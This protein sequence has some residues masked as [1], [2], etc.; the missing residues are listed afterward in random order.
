M[1]NVECPGTV[2]FL[3]RHWATITVLTVTAVAFVIRLYFMGRFTEYNADSYYYMILG[4]S[5]RDSFEYTVRGLLHTKYLPG[6]P[7]AMWLVSYI[8]GGIENAA[9]LIALLCG[10]MTVVVTYGLARELF[11]RRV[12]VLAAVLIALQP[13]YLAWTSQPMTEGIFTFLFAGS[14]WLVLTGCKRGSMFRRLLGAA[15]GGACFLVRWEG[16]LLFP[17]VA[18]ILWIYRHEAGLSWWEPVAMLALGGGPIGAYA[19]RNL[20]LTGSIS[21]YVAEYS[22]Y[23]PEVISL[24]VLRTR[25][26]AYAWS[27]FSSAFFGVLAYIS[28]AWALLRK[29]W[30]PLLVMGGWFLLYL[31]MHMFWYYAYERFMA[32]AMPAVSILIAFLVCDVAG[33]LVAGD[34]GRMLPV[35]GVDAEQGGGGHLS[36][37]R[38]VRLAG[39]WLVALL[40]IG[41]LVNCF[42]NGNN[43]AQVLAD[44][45]GD[46]HGGRG[47]VRAADW[48]GENDPGSRV[49]AS[50]GPYFAWLYDSG[51][52]VYLRSVPW[53]LP[54]EE[55]TVPLTNASIDDSSI[56]FLVE[57]GVKYLVLHYSEV[58]EKANALVK[59]GEVSPGRIEQVAYWEDL[60]TEPTPAHLMTT[61]IFKVLPHGE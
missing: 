35:S 27:G 37:P 39:P 34:G 42:V 51:E 6:F 19:I 17:L 8:A 30:R 55:G 32:P 60:Y 20:A 43:A 28:F 29:R 61:T 16:I 46:D 15:A 31:A 40:V 2:A 33:M 47:M 45:Y 38:P 12:G 1:R 3:K 18:L 53:D 24:G 59:I 49:A 50:A 21:S 26:V 22:D 41:L 14:V 13:T 9:K 4:R 44:A 36:L 57:D 7:V 11:D 56:D 58:E 25:F 52:I 23:R 5:L 10:S 48:L 54:V